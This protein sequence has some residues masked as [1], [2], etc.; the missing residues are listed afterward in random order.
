MPSASRRDVLQALQRLIDAQAAED[1]HI[2]IADHRHG[3]T[4]TLYIPADTT[5]A[6][7]TAVAAASS[8]ASAPAYID[9]DSCQA[10]ILA[11][12]AEAG[13]RLTTTKLLT[14]MHAAGRTWGDSTVRVALA[15]MV[16][17]GIITNRIDT[18]PRGYGLP[19][20]TN[21]SSGNGGG[22]GGGNRG[23]GDTDRPSGTAED[24]INP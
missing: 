13:R 17:K 10:D 12:L 5:A 15:A 2:T 18:E 22:N 16:R 7:I 3:I 19:E 14:A 20:W 24:H 1:L 21:G 4:T 8:D 9:P 23:N 6:A 11:T